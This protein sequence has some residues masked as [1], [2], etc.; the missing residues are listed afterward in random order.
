MLDLPQILLARNDDDGL[1]RLISIL[2][3][4]GIFI[5]GNILQ[6]L[7]KY[8]AQKRKLELQRRTMA[9]APPPSQPMQRPMA[10][11]PR[12]TGPAMRRFGQPAPAHLRPAQ[13]VPRAL[14]AQRAKVAGRPVPILRKLTPPAPLP[15][16]VVTRR[17]APPPHLRPA[18]AQRPVPPQPQVTSPA[19]AASPESASRPQAARTRATKI[20][21]VLNPRTLKQV[22]VLTEIL[23]PPVSLRSEPERLP[24]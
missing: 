4:V 20:Q 8:Q 2:V 18:P 24:S 9:P 12:P 22:Y 10:A 23:Q 15:G 7:Q 3:I 5:F 17:P 21:A 1:S 11:K 13:A 14:A 6:W 19:P 16:A